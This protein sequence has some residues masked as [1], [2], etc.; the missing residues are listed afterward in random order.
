MNKQ[1]YRHLCV[2][3]TEDISDY[4]KSKMIYEHVRIIENILNEL[5]FLNKEITEKELRIRIQY[6]KNGTIK[7]FILSNFEHRLK[8][9]PPNFK[10]ITVTNN[11]D[12]SN[13]E[14]NE[15]LE[16]FYK[17]NVGGSLNLSRNKIIELPEN[18]GNLF[19]INGNLNL[20]RN[21]IKELPESFGN[22]IIEGDLDLN[23][24][25]LRNLNES[26]GN[27][28]IG[29]SLSLVNNSLS[30]LPKNFIKITVQGEFN[31][32]FNV[33]NHNIPINSLR[34]IILFKEWLKSYY[35]I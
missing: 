23:K 4:I 25:D 31:I 8:K 1:M 3:L 21:N 32:C 19:H 34:N 18:F 17:I 2:N 29:G 12:L 22:L 24:N 30:K 20:S 33:L 11:L 10:N 28:I 7:N 13:N 16:D 6:N 35:C 27:L 9:L 15:L 5:L 26:F 14:I